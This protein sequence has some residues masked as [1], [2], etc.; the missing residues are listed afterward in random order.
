MKQYTLFSNFRFFIPHWQ[1]K[2]KRNF[3]HNTRAAA[4][5]N[6]KTSLFQRIYKKKLKNKTIFWFLP[7]LIIFVIFPNSVATIW[8]KFIYFFLHFFHIFLYNY[9]LRNTAHSCSLWET[10]CST[11]AITLSAGTVTICARISCNELYS[12]PRLVCHIYLRIILCQTYVYVLFI[13][14]M[15]WTRITR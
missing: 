12:K 11:D 5:N 1:K 15:C 6:N 7:L 10:L 8:L 3:S 13:Y 9:L 4:L 2:N 14:P